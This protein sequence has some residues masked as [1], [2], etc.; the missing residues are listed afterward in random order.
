MAVKKETD[1][2]VKTDVNNASEK[3]AL[4]N[5]AEPAAPS[6]DEVMTTIHLF[7]DDDKYKDD[8]VVGVNGKIYQ[9]QRGIDVSV[10]LS[11]AEVIRESIRQDQ[12]TAK[13]IQE[14]KEKY[15][16]KNS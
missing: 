1:N 14:A 5:S 16:R 15:R 9:I 8:L 4:K 7:K 12:A 2:T 11:V 13:K 6:S 3:E 10:P